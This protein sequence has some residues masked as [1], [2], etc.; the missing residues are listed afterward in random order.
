M[1]KKILITGG[2][3]LLGS[4]LAE[5]LYN[6]EY[7]VFILSRSK[8][9]DA[10]YKYFTWDIDKEYIQ[11]GALDVDAI[12]HLAGAGIADRRW[13]TSRKKLILDSRIKSTQL[14]AKKLKELNRKVPHYIGASAIG[15]YG[16]R[17]EHNYQEEE[18][19]NDLS[20]FLVEVTRKWESAHS[21]LQNHA[22]SFSIL[23]IGIVFSTQGGAL[24][25]MLIP[26]NFKVGN[27]FGNG[28]QVMSWVHIDDIC[29]MIKYILENKLEG[30]YN[31][32]SPLPANGKEI[33][34]EIAN[35]KKGTLF[36]FGVPEFILKIIF[37]EMAS[38]I[39]SSTSVS[40]EKIIAA[41]FTFK[42]EKVKEALRDLL[43]PSL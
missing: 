11:E 22:S 27:Y 18:E 41:G 6:H 35:I 12:I 1:K 19:S 38:T 2:T 30:T 37:G 42:Y 40:A 20:D 31:A 34:S 15:I 36:Q 39:L 24:K 8:K 28:K 29:S 33:I 3:G 7:E 43:K 16:D 10:A 14:I 32:V 23:R 9:K 5:F 4:A 26:F 17:D 13:S 25:S 21:N